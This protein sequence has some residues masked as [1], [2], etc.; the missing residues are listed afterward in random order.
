MMLPSTRIHLRLQLASFVGMLAPVAVVGALASVDAPVYLQI[1]AAAAILL[2]YVLFWRPKVIAPLV[3]ARDDA[4][5]AERP[6]D[7]VG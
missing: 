1:V 7:G 2:A 6:V 5:I 3:R 4:A